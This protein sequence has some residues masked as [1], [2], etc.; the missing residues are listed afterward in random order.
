[1]NLKELKEHVINYLDWRG[2]GVDTKVTQWIN[3][4]RLDI[5]LKFD[6]PFLFAT[7]ITTT[8][9]D[10][11]YHVPPD[12]L[13]HMLILMEDEGMNLRV[14]YELTPGYWSKQLTEIEWKRLIE[15]DSPPY[16]VIWKGTYFTII[17]L[18]PEGRTIEMWYYRKPDEF[19]V[20]TDEDYMSITYPEVIISGAVLRGAIYLDDEA[21]IAKFQAIYSEQ[22]KA[23]IAREN[24]KKADRRGN[25][26]F[27]T[28]KDFDPQ[29]FRRLTGQY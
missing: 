17:P 16:R 29:T 27:R 6:F 5:A 2:S 20:D 14:I 13:D 26:R 12:Y 10:S 25:L 23:M 19:T 21:K 7:A 4:T 1:M 22:L 8:T 15:I 18:P 24:R 28:W 3:L 9:G 11:T